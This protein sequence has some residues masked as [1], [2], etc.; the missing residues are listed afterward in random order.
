MTPKGIPLLSGIIISLLLLCS[1]STQLKNKINLSISTILPLLSFLFLSCFWSDNLSYSL[2]KFIQILIVIIIIKILTL[3]FEPEKQ[4][5]LIDY[6][7]FAGIFLSVLPFFSNYYGDRFIGV[8]QH[9]NTL[10]FIAALSGI[11]I[12]YRYKRNCISLFELIVRLSI[13]LYVL[14]AANSATSLMLLIIYSVLVLMP[15]KITYNTPIIAILALTTSLIQLILSLLGRDLS[16]TGRTRF[17]SA[18]WIEMTTGPKSTLIFGHSLGGFFNTHNI[19]G[20]SWQ[21]ASKYGFPLDV[22]GQAHNGYIQLFVENGLIGIFLFTL[23]IMLLFKRFYKN[24]EDCKHYFA[25]LICLLISNFTESRIFYTG[26]GTF[27]FIY[28]IQFTASIEKKKN[29]ISNTFNMLQ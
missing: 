28:I 23:V 17:W 18:L 14:F 27:I 29:E 4:V 5:Q 26:I 9:P 12:I 19:N 3:Y 24:K 8:Y 2:L 20:P 15:T 6:S 1:H 25:L 7:L 11:F 13:I 21:F 16:F 10:G 22:T